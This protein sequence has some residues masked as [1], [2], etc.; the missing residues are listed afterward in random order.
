LDGGR[1]GSVNYNSDMIEVRSKK[2]KVKNTWE[3]P[4]NI[5]IKNGKIIGSIRVWGMGRN[6]EAPDIRESSKRE[7]TNSKHVQRVRM[8][9]P[10]NIVFD[11]L[12]ITGVKRNPLYFAPGVTYSK[13]I[14]SE[15]KGKSVRVGI[16]LDAESA[17]NTFEKNYL[18]FRIEEKSTCCCPKTYRKIR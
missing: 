7:V 14:N 1:R 4:E 16:Y 10:K 5:L 6:G 11:R 8:N 9:A 13:L 2:D 12:T 15:M 17:Y 18:H 3:R